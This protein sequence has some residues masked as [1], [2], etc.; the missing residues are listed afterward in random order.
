MSR[1]LTSVPLFALCAVV[2]AIVACG[3]Q[4]LPEA[5][6]GDAARG[7][8]VFEQ[9][10]GNGFG[11]ARCHCADA[12]GGCGLDAPNIQ[13]RTYAEVDARVRGAAAHPGG[14]FNLTD[15]QIADVAAFLAS[16]NAN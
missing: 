4:P 7:A 16:V 2:L 14:K 15:Q 5:P 1:V 9:G 6:V 11:C 3:T 10:E 12:S 13:G 8:V